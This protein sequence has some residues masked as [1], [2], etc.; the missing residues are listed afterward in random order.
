VKQFPRLEKDGSV[1]PLY[2]PC[3]LVQQVKQ[4]A[5]SFLA[6]ELLHLLDEPAGVVQ[7]KIQRPGHGL[8]AKLL[9]LPD[10]PAGVVKAKMQLARV[11]VASSLARRAQE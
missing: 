6:T 1:L 8:A 2:D 5:A 10:E 3:R 9:H 7:R 11:A 4:F